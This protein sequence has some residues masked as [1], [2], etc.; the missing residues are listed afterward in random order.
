MRE[1]IANMNSQIIHFKGTNDNMNLIVKDLVSKRNGMEKQVGELNKEETSNLSYIKSFE[2]DI[3]DM[4]QNYIAVHFMLIQD[5]KGLKSKI[6]ELYRKYVQ[7]ESK[8]QMEGID[9]QRQFIKERAHLESTVKGLK[10]KFKKNIELHEA[11]N[12]R[13]MS[14]NEELIAEINDLKR[15]KKNLKD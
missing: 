15:E 14:Q 6:I 8:K 3:S 13:I 9:Q 10:E 5:Y 7:E 1:Q 12:K 4:Y 11:D 2:Y